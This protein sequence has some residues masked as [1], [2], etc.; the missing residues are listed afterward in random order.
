MLVLASPALAQT[1]P[2]ESRIRFITRTVCV[3]EN[4]RNYD[5]RVSSARVCESIA[6]LNGPDPPEVT[7]A[8]QDAATVAVL[9]ARVRSREG[10]TPADERR[11]GLEGPRR[12]R[13][14]RGR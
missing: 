5:D 13:P 11:R 4:I 2:E 9:R 10:T 1:V 8:L 12:R 7:A 6:D 3:E 14:V